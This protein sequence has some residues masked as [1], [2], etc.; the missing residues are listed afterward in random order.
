MP[1]TAYKGFP[2][3]NLFVFS[4]RIGLSEFADIKAAYLSEDGAPVQRDA[5]Y[6]IRPGTDISALS[7]E[8][9]AA[10]WDELVKAFKPIT[11]HMVVRTA[12]VCEEPNARPAVD[13]WGAMAEADGAMA[14]EVGAFDTLQEAAI[15]LA[16]SAAE[17]AEIE[18]RIAATA[19]AA[20]R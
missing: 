7:P 6:F 2:D 17:C 11:R 13:A 4:G 18:Q 3:L 16:L 1:V 19:A 8:M 20:A 5:L 12:F 10:V 14:T 9:L 15:W